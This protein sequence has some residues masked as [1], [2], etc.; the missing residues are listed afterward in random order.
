MAGR[1]TRDWK[2][3]QLYLDDVAIDLAYT[4]VQTAPDHYENLA[5]LVGCPVDGVSPSL[6]V[7][8]ETDD[9]D[10]TPMTPPQEPAPEPTAPAPA[11]HVYCSTTIEQPLPVVTAD[12]WLVLALAAGGGVL[13][14]GGIALTALAL[15]RRR[16]MRPRAADLQNAGDF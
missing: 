10:T 5:M 8:G 14:G 15:R 13:A 4:Y 11:T 3:R 1:V 6:A 7:A 16:A 2:L 12:T 9:G